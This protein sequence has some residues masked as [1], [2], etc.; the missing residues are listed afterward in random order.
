MNSLRTAC[1]LVTLPDVHF[2]HAV[3]SVA[4]LLD[5]NAARLGRE[6]KTGGS[7]LFLSKLRLF[8]GTDVTVTSC[9]KKLQKLLQSCREVRALLA[10]PSN[11]F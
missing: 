11:W 1:V 10:C 2:A 6:I 3:W 4:P 9:G 5:A 7:V 8:S